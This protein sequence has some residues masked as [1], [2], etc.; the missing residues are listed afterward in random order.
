[1][2]LA[3][4][5]GDESLYES[6]RGSFPVE[7]KDKVKAAIESRWP[8]PRT[9]R[10]LAI[11]QPH[12]GYVLKSSTISRSF[13]GA[14]L[15]CVQ[16]K[17]ERSSGANFDTLYMPYVIGDGTTTVALRDEPTCHTVKFEQW[18]DMRDGTDI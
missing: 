9:F 17:G 4:C 15:G 14:W 13:Y 3:G 5:P 2:A 1:M 10:V 7:Y 12:D 16:V 6:H 18:L 11:S 8:A